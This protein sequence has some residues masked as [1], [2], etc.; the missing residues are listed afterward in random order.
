MDI[1]AEKLLLIEQILRTNDMCVLTDIREYLSKTY[2]PI[3]GYEPDGTPIT[4]QEFIKMIE[5]AE[6]EV[7]QG[8]YQTIEEVEK[9]ARDW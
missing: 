6:K 5:E 1:Q 4:Q 8:N 9:E 7:E 2:N 3:V